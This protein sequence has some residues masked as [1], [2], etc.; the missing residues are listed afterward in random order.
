M[1]P[2]VGTALSVLS[3]VGLAVWTWFKKKNDDRETALRKDRL[4]LV[5]RQLS[6]L[7]GPLLVSCE[8]GRSAYQALLRKLRRPNGIF[9][10]DPPPTEAEIKEWFHWMVNVLNPINE[11]REQLILEKCHLI[12][13]EKVPDCFLEFSAHVAGYRAILAKWK[14]NDYTERFSVH[15][16]PR[17]LD[18]YARAAFTELKL[19][20][21]RLLGLL[22]P[23]GVSSKQE[24]PAAR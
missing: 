21:G 23:K 9:H 19:E 7:Y 14:A 11:R 18:A 10:P 6:E 13:E 2:F 5:N 20:Q 16:F 15:D 8:V 12:K 24:A 22:E 3:G 1:D 17:A 4:E